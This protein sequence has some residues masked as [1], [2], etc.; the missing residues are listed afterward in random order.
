MKPHE[1]KPSFSL[2]KRVAWALIPPT[3]LLL[4]LNAFWF[5]TGAIDAANRAYDRSLAASLKSIAGS[6]HATGGQITVDI[7]YSALEVFEEDVQ[8][9]VFYAVIGP[10]GKVITGYDDLPAAR[11]P[12]DDE[13]EKLSVID[14][15]FREQPI[16]LATL[17][18]RLYDPELAGGDSVTV[19][20]AETTEARTRLAFSLFIDSLRPQFLLI[21]GGLA[22]VLIVIRNAFDP[23]MRLRSAAQ[24]PAPGATAA[25]LPAWRPTSSTRQKSG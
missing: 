25:A 8:E 18:K 9:R 20:F 21:V 16:R 10:D 17:S 23:L 3:T 5:Y 14:T 4:L 19:L 7:P 6:I 2:R 11:T 12:D 13:D 22:L 24:W 15:T 1:E